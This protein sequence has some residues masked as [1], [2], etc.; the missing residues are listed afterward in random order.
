MTSIRII[1]AAVALLALSSIS[2]RAQTVDIQT[3][4]QQP[5]VQAAVRACTADHDRLCSTT[6]PG[7]GRIVR[8]LAAQ[9]AQLSPTCRAAMERARDDL[10]AAGIATANAH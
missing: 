4:M 9:Q 1:P 6:I 5:A 2:A 10:V 8:C 3:A 7:G